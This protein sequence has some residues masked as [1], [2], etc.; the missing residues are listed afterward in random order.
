M[1]KITIIIAFTVIGLFGCGDNNKSLN[2]EKVQKFEVQEIKEILCTTPMQTIEFI[3]INPKWAEQNVNCMT[4]ELLEDTEKAL[5]EHVYALPATNAKANYLGYEALLAFSA[6]NIKYKSKAA[7]YKEKWQE[8]EKKI[9]HELTPAIEYIG[10]KE[11]NQLY[12][13]Q[14]AGDAGFYYVL[15]KT[16]L[17][18]GLIETYTSRIG[19][20]N[21]Y[22]DFSKLIINC[23]T[24]EYLY[25]GGAFVGG[26]QF[27]L[28]ETIE[29]TSE[30]SM[31]TGL[32]K[33]SSK[34]DLVNFICDE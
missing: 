22:T 6:N 28:A 8:K 3:A 14:V 29:D 17:P 10:S 30:K 2:K 26:P 1:N 7:K 11:T 25:I 9:K 4:T 16:V 20:D 5:Y 27:R 15:K 18:S 23:N 12:R 21:A 33:G 31:W 24:M 19:K 34:Y 13:S 32:V